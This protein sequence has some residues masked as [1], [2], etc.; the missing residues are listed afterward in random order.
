MLHEGLH[1][2]HQARV[3]TGAQR[4]QGQIFIA[5]GIQGAASQ[6]QQLPRRPFAHRPV[7][8]AGLTETAAPAAAPGYLQPQPVVHRPPERHHR[9]IRKGCLI[10]VTDNGTLNTAMIRK[11]RLQVLK[12]VTVV[13]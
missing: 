8:H 9:L 7:N 10:Q 3:I 4:E 12:A 2:R 5:A 13:I 11:F 6:F 1:Q